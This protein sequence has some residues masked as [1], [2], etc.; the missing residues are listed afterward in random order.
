MKVKPKGINRNKISWL[1]DQPIDVKAEVL[2]HHLELSRM[3]INDILED[4]VKQLS[5]ERYSRAKPHGGQYGRWG[6][7]PGSVRVGHE[8][9]RVDVPRVY[10]SSEQCHKS[11]GSYERLRQLE[12][13]RDQILKAVLLGLSTQ[14]YQQVIQQ[15]LD[16]FGLSRSSVSSHFIQESREKLKS[17]ENRNLSCYEFVALFIDG[18]SLA[19][20]QIVIVLGVT[21]DGE[22]L[23]LGFIQ[24]HTENAESIRQ[25]LSE[26]IERG[27][28]YRQG[29]LCVIDGSKGI[30]KAVKETFGEYALVQRCHWHKREN[31]VSYL[32]ERDQQTYR[33][34]LNKAHHADTY[35][36]A[37][38]QLLTI[39][40]ELEVINR[41]AA[42]SLKEGLEETLT[43]HRLGLMELF[44]RS[45]ST[46]NCI[47]NLNSQ[48]KKYIGKVKHWKSSQQR[49]R[50][51]A[52]AML[53]I[54]QK[55]RKVNQYKKL[56]LM[57]KKI[58]EEIDLRIDKK[59]K[60]A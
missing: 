24:T 48:L 44:G 34:R 30:R 6:Y 26:L 3:L 60:A 4:E 47:E 55:M 7:N 12:P 38:Q 18:K 11:L 35:G 8:K 9:V 5:G 23:P 54:E 45:F 56:Y 20:E 36:E 21:S 2:R 19:K 43:L 53:E 14:D 22:K 27:F 50:W 59:K 13:V 42:K 32:N 58:R 46:T 15:L 51:I 31:V 37:K 10:D 41:S 49:Y 39:K 33:R 1:L 28:S 16:S 25:L 29:I 57:Q 40:T 17:Y 52:S